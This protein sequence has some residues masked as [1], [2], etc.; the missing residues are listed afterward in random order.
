MLQFLKDIWGYGYVQINVV[1]FNTFNRTT[2]VSSGG[3]MKWSHDPIHHTG[4]PYKNCSAASPPA[5]TSSKTPTSTEAKY[6]L[7]SKAKYKPQHLRGRL[8]SKQ[9]NEMKRFKALL[10]SLPQG[11]IF[12]GEIRAGD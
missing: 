1:Q 7:E 5:E 12:D 3:P 10:E 9:M 11:Y 8:F 2:I 6:Q 4:V